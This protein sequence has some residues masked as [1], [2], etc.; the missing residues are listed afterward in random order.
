MKF[1]LNW[2]TGLGEVGFYVIWP[3]DLVFK[4]G[5]DRLSNFDRELIKYH[6]YEV[7]IKLDN[8]LRRSRILKDVT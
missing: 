8:W 6:T 4:L 2:T 1:Q 5:K 3:G 7:S